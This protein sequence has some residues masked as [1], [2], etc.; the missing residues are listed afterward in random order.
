MG[1]VEQSLGGEAVEDPRH[2]EQ[3]RDIGLAKEDDLFWVHPQRQPD[4]GN[5]VSH[6]LEFFAIP[7][8]GQPVIVGD[9]VQSAISFS[10]LQARFD[11]PQ[12]VTQVRYAGGLDAR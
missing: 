7:H 6:A 8:R 2:F 3:L 4:S 12:V 10:Q 9:K 1:A 11:Q 5:I